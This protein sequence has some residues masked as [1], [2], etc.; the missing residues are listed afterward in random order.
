MT[1]RRLHSL[2]LSLASNGEDKRMRALELITENEKSRPAISLR[3]LNNLKYK[4]RTRETSRA[5]R[6]RLMIIMYPN[7][8]MA[9]IAASLAVSPRTS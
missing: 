2:C 5:Q 1:A 6:D 7:H 8:I 3:R 9:T 4:F